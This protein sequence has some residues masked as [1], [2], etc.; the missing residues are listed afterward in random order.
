MI[1][2]Y[3]W[4][5][6]FSW[7]AVGIFGSIALVWWLLYPRQFDARIRKHAKKQMKESSY[8]KSFGR[9]EV[10]LLDEHLQSTS[11]TGSSTYVWSAV[12]RAEMDS[13]YLYIFL[14]GPLGYP[15]RLSEIGRETAQSARDFINSRIVRR[16]GSEH[17]VPHDRSA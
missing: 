12:D 7:A 1:C 16:R 15:I 14:S 11:P 8:A 13:E 5:D 17:S 4:R 2:Y 3:S 10:V 9:Y 6:G